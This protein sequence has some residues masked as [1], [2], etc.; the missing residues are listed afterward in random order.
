[1]TSLLVSAVAGM[2]MPSNHEE[3]GASCVHAANTTAQCCELHEVIGYKASFGIED[4]SSGRK[5]LLLLVV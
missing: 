2:A 4:T 5:G 1:M 3:V